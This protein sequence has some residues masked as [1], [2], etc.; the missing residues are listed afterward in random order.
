MK[1]SNR[2]S[3]L[4][5]QQPRTPEIQDAIYALEA[6]RDLAYRRP[7]WYRESSDCTYFKGRGCTGA[8]LRALALVLRLEKVH[9]VVIYKYQNGDMYHV[10]MVVT[11][12]D[13]TYVIPD[14]FAEG[15]SG[16]GPRGL[17][18]ARAMLRTKNL[19]NVQEAIVSEAFF[20]SIFSKCNGRD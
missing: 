16:E 11:A 7:G 2:I 9:S 10:G 20:E 14:G 4:Y 1:I 17:I 3:S 6:E 5:R 13:H 15:Y 19:N 8:A 12:G 18:Q